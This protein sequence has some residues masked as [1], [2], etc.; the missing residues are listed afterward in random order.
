MKILH[1]L[2]RTHADLKAVLGAVSPPDEVGS[3]DGA[4][5]PE[6]PGC[7]VPAIRASLHA[8]LERLLRRPIIARI[9]SPAS[10]PASVEHD[11]ELPALF[12][13]ITTIARAAAPA[14]GGGGRADPW[15]EDPKDGTFSID[16]TLDYAD[17]WRGYEKEILEAVTGTVENH[18]TFLT[19]EQKML[20]ERSPREFLELVPRPE[21]AELLAF[22]TRMIGGAQHVVELTVAARPES[23]RAIH[24]IA[25][26]PNLVP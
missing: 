4:A 8:K 14:I 20:L 19:D 11:D 15:R 18:I 10:E 21:S 22:A 6:R 3:A 2:F 9:V 13:V 26:V 17:R 24:H 25:V 5:P 23:S 1:D 12:R 16:V 7:L